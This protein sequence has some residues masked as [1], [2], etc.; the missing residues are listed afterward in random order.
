VSDIS[1]NTAHFFGGG[2]KGV[3]AAYADGHVE[4][5]NK[6]KM[7]CGYVAGSTYWFY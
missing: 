5:H 3:N 4:T 1:P 2:L 7:H 6:A